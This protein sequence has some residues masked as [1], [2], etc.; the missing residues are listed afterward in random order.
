MSMQQTRKSAITLLREACP[1][2]ERR[3]TAPN[4][5][6]HEYRVPGGS[7]RSAHDLAILIVPG[8]P[9]TREGESE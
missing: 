2:L 9:L 6:Q 4:N 8:F 5:G 7:W 1:T 3:E